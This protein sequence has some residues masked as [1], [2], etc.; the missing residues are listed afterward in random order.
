MNATTT[1]QNIS[2]KEAAGESNNHPSPE[3]KKPVRGDYYM[4]VV[5]GP[6]GSIIQEADWKK[7]VGDATGRDMNKA[8]KKNKMTVT[9][10]FQAEAWDK[11][12]Q[13]FRT[14]RKQN[15]LNSRQALI[16]EAFS[17]AGQPHSK[18][19]ENALRTLLPLF[20]DATPAKTAQSF[21][22]IIKAIVYAAGDLPQPNTGAD[23][24]DESDSKEKLH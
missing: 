5:L 23:K 14:S 16:D 21:D 15:Q 19:V 20:K 18:R 22:R 24:Q 9:R 8:L 3:A 2:N 11:A 10:V 4:T 12:R 7:V 13:E 17:S 6:N 1:T